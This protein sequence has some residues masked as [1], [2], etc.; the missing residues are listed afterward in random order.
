MNSNYKILL[1]DQFENPIAG[2][3]LM[4]NNVK[5]TSDGNGEIAFNIDL[6]V[7]NHQFTII[8]PLNNESITDN[9]QIIP[10]LTGNEDI[11]MYYGAN[12]YYRVKVFDDYGKTLKAE[13]ISIVI[14]GK[15][16]NVKTNKNGIAG[17]KLNKFKVGKYTASINYKGFKVSNKITVRSTLTAKNKSVKKKKVVKFTAKLV[18]VN[19]KALKAKKIT[20]KI[21]GKTYKVKTNKKGIATLKLKKLKAG[22]YTVKT[23]FGAVKISNK[24]IIKK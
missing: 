3:E 5:M 16:Y 18:N 4:I 15:V 10:R 21:K 2:K 1:K 9:I 12:K 11:V 17:V 7:G 22:R 23:S 14:N 8:N 6:N 13:T 20:F 19:G 24:L